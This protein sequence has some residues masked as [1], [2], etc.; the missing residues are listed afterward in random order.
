V[1]FSVAGKSFAA[2]LA[3]AATVAVAGCGSSDSGN[4]GAPPDY[5]R[6]LAGAPPPLAALYRQGNELLPGGLDAY[7]RRLA[8]LRGYPA[9]VN[10]WGSWCGP[11]RFEFPHLQQVAAK[12]GKRVA[13]IGVDSDDSEDAAATFLEG[14]P[15]PYP[16][17]SDPDKEITN[18][19]GATLGLPATAFYDRAG[20][21][22][23][24]KHGPYTSAADLRA[25]VESH[26]LK[27]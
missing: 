24:L 13:F 7:E 27:G 22:V 11:C 19:L 25:D 2:V 10:V 23:F 5:D 15:L 14:E 9:V 26:A 21:L 18:H 12:L 6:A 20:E 8:G 4:G 16:S 3:L 1:T 17:Y